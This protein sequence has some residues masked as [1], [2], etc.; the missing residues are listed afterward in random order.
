MHVVLKGGGGRGWG[1][2]EKKLFRKIKHAKRKFGKG[3]NL[4]EF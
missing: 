2:R 1:G 4:K 3:N